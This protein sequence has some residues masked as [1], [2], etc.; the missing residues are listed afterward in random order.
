MPNGACGRAI[1]P[2]YGRSVAG[3]GQGVDGRLSYRATVAAVVAYG[4]AMA[5]VEAAAVVYLQ[6]ALGGQVG[7]VLPLRP[8]SETGS[9]VS[10]EAVRELA[11]L[12]MIAAVGLLAGRTS[13]ER[14]AWAAV[15]FG[16]WDV[17]YYGSLYVVSGWPPSLATLDILF[18]L[19]VPWIGPVWS[20]IVVS[21]A[22]VAVGLIAARVV[23]SGRALRLD[24]RHWLAGALGGVLVVGSYVSDTAS[25]LAGGLPGP[26][27]WPV[28]G[29]GMAIALL[30]AVDVLRPPAVRPPVPWRRP[31][32]AP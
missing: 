27:P 21:A 15:V 29:L 32:T 23:R 13:L 10:I 17:G 24:R 7:A 8:A 31:R 18:L 9:L 1:Q 30:A 11:T 3:R 20:P 4:V 26:Y 19:P 6:L 28:F 2:C 14:L 25:V 5:F 22:L 12:V 16:T